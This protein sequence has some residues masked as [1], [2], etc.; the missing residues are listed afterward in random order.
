MEF[1][2]EKIK[3]RFTN[4]FKEEKLKKF[5]IIAGFAGIALIFIS[6]FFS[7]CSN[8][9]KAKENTVTINSDISEYKEETEKNLADIV[10]SIDGA[11]N[12]RVYVTVDSSTECIYAS[13]DKNSITE[14]KGD[15]TSDNNT[16]TEK[17]YI[18]LRMS[19]GTEQAVLLKQVEPKIRGVLVL[20]SG[21]GDKVV[22]GR[23]LEAVTKALNIS[24]AKVCVTKLSY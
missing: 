11:G 4:L 17:N 8:E 15:S 2:N 24:S 16:T 18:T 23:V 9:D 20:C 14:N 7:G 10:S 22:N 19:D 5:I 6:N 3:N 21:G 1:D 12:T 13:N